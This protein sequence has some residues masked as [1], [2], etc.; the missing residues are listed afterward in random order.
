[1]A[2][3][4]FF[5]TDALDAMTKI[6]NRKKIKLKETQLLI[7]GFL[8]VIVI[9][10]FLLCLPVSSKNGEWTNYVDALFTATSS[11][12]VTG[13]V[14][15]DTYL[16]WTLFG[17]IV[18]LVLIQIGGLGVMT[19][20]TTTMM[21]LGRKIGI[22]ERKILMQSAGTM[23]LSGIV[24][25]VRRITIGTAIFE[26]VG[27][28]L[29]ATRLCP[30]LG[31]WEGIYSSIFHSI[32]AFC[33]AGYDIM[34]RYGAFGSLAS[35]SGD[36]IV[37]L[38]IMGLIFMGGIG[39]IVWSDVLD[40]GFNLKKFS[41]HTKIALYGSTVLIFLGALLFWLFEKNNLLLNKSAGESLLICLFMS[42]TPRTAG[43]ATISY[44]A[45]TDRSLLL[46]TLHMLIG[47]CPG[48][49]A[50]G[51][52]VTTLVV[53]ILGVV[54]SARSD[55]DIVIGNRRLEKNLVNQA[56]GLLAVYLAAIFLSI[57]V[58]CAVEPFGLGDIG[59]EVFSAINT[60]GLST[61][62]TPDLTLTSQIILMLLMLMGR[63][64][65]LSFTLAFTQNKPI[66]TKYPIEKILIG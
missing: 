11:T 66:L 2:F 56:L 28:C 61:G 64:G 5:P 24:L 51:I 4:R 6:K 34:G 62:I 47:G 48:G 59:I 40:C 8:A 30:K 22:Y 15:V 35:F 44:A 27:A 58:M 9:G 45:A 65:A 53:I 14:T 60:V 39:F 25:L 29:L 50:G 42:I 57:L 37:N 7:L 49:T 54:S 16:H 32:S 52:K 46:T 12:C 43:F 1:M 41:L 26:G 55:G 17:Q 63:V 18:I 19:V 3:W 20:I 23:R 21:V 13:L 38:T 10:S 33:N 36:W 31:F